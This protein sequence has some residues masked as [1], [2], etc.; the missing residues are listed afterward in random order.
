MIRTL[1]RVPRDHL[2]RRR[3]ALEAK[4]IADA[5]YVADVEGLARLRLQLLALDKEYN[6]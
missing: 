2:A 5:Q 6:Q 1:R 4:R 3:A